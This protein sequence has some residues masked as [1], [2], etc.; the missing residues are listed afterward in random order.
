MIIRL[1]FINGY[2]YP[3]DSFSRSRLGRDKFQEN[4]LDTITPFLVKKGY[5]FEIFNY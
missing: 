1:Q 2:F 3:T 5:M 4:K